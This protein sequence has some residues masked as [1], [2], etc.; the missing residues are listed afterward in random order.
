[1]CVGVSPQ[2]CRGVCCEV[3]EWAGREREVRRWSCT[4]VTVTKAVQM[5]EAVER[6]EQKR[7]SPRAHHHHQETEG[8]ARGA[9]ACW[10]LGIMNHWCCPLR[11]TRATPSRRRS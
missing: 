1:M 3:P 7:R 9:S 5:E 10:C 6:P 2:S 11:L 8:H 4:P